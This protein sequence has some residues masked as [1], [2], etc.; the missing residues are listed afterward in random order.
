MTPRLLDSLSSAQEM[1]DVSRTLPSASVLNTQGPA[2][3]FQI[4][5]DLS[6]VG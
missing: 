1:V 5:K 6:V 4:L 2:S 3:L